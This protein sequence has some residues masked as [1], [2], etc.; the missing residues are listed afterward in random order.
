MTLEATS[1]QP[2]P[3]AGH[4]LPLPGNGTGRSASD[5]SPSLS[6]LS[7]CIAWLFGLEAL[8]QELEERGDGRGWD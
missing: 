8:L 6:R 4:L 7:H 3:D 5:G 1:I 2:A